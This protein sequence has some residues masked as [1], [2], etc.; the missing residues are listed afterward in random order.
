MNNRIPRILIILTITNLMWISTSNG[1]E[2]ETHTLLSQKAIAASQLQ[3]YLTTVLGFEFPSG[4][5]ELIG[6]GLYRRV[7]ELIANEGAVK[8]DSPDPR[9]RYHFH[10]PTK[11][12]S[13]AGLSSPFLG[14]FESSVLWSQ[15]PNQGLG[16][17]HSWKDARDSY[18]NALTSTNVTDRKRYYAETFVTLGHLLHHVQDAAAPSHTRN[19]WHIPVF[20]ENKFFPGLKIDR[21]HSWS[22]DHGGP[23]INSA[24]SL[25]FDPS[26]FNQT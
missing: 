17:K 16:G 22:R 26:L 3:N 24:V 21:F 2:V 10:D 5:G 1:F 8:E 7:D 23:A 11:A 14:T 12:W 20:T 18:F 4:T 25:P 13:Q 9:V 15:N 6:Q 19:D